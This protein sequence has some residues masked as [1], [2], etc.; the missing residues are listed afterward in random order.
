VKK[1]ARLIFIIPEV[2]LQDECALLPN[3]T[4]NFSSTEFGALFIGNIDPFI[5]HTASLM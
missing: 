5:N 2:K 3:I 1:P 4:N